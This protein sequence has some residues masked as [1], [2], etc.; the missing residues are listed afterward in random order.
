VLGRSLLT[1]TA[2]GD[3][4]TLPPVGEE[5]PVVQNDLAGLAR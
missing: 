5:P 1:D 3:P 4:A 2:A